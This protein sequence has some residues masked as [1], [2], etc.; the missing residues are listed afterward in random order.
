MRLIG[1]IETDGFLDEL[2]TCHCIVLYDIDARSYRRFNDQGYYSDPV[3]HHA[4]GPIT[5]AIDLMNS[6]DELYFHNGH[7]FDYP[8]LKKLYPEFNPKPGAMRD[9]LTMASAVYRDLRN[10]DFRNMEKGKY[11][12][13]F[14]KRQLVGMHRLE[15]WGVR[16]GLEKG[17]IA[18]EDG[19]TDWSQW[20]PEMEDYCE[21]DVQVTVKLWEVLTSEKNLTLHPWHCHDLDNRFQHLM[22]RQE[23]QGFLFDEPAA[24]ALFGELEQK[25]HDL[26]GELQEVFHPFYKREKAIVPKRDNSRYGYVAGAEFQKLKLTEF[27][28]GSRDHIGMRLQRLYGWEPT[29][30]GSDGKPTVDEK[31]LSA[32]PYS[33]I[34][35]LM[36][37]LLVAKRVGQLAEGKKAWLKYVRNDG[38]LHGRI[39]PMGT[40]TWRCSHKD[41]NVGQ[42]PSVRLDKD[43]NILWGLE[44]GYGADCRSLF[45]VPDGSVLCGHDASGLELRCLA[46]YMA[47]YDGGEYAKVVLEGDVHTVNQH[48]IGLNLRAN[49]KTWMYAFLYGAG[50]F[51]LGMNVL[52]DFDEAKRQRFYGKYGT[53]G[54]KFQKAVVKLGKSSKKRVAEGLPALAA[55]IE[56]VRSKA[57]EQGGLRGLDGRWLEVRAQHSALNTL[58][59]SCGAILMKRWLVL[60]DEELHNAGLVP[61]QFK[62]PDQESHYEYVANVHDEGQTEVVE[63]M[64]ETYDQLAVA[65]FAKAGEFYDFRVRLDG[66]GKSGKCWMETH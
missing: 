11:P 45:I 36:D 38:R 44:G 43:D 59:Q 65:A 7:G 66:E 64:V 31:V 21:Q 28:P 20:T 48:A 6:A 13:D 46:H 34:P 19:I 39:D 41:P 25:L 18:D 5:D 40:V 14:A 60:L 27:N 56:A 49:A 57:K 58:L 16:L 24:A 61:H 32:L 62:S 50:D 51:T 37:Y 17:S 30:Y 47:R 15:A 10:L 63:P 23:R 2:T 52:V 42:V 8:A 1:D 33:T 29:A 4:W 54:L 3:P 53:S 26:T 35:L 55:L 9:T 22:S 12:D